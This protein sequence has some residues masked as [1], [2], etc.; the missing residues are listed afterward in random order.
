MNKH[1]PRRQEIRTTIAKIIRELRADGMTYLRRPTKF[2]TVDSFNVSEDLFDC[3]LFTSWAELQERD[4]K[5]YY[6]VRIDHDV[7][8][9]GGFIYSFDLQ[10]T[11]PADD[12]TWLKELI[13][14]RFPTRT[15]QEQIYAATGA[16]LSNEQIEQVRG[17]ICDLQ[18]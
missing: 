6:Q 13:E 18:Q 2:L 14:L 17:I 4:T 16:W 8:E 3:N 15:K 5:N 9:Y 12:H 11:V 10:Q 1:D 7:D